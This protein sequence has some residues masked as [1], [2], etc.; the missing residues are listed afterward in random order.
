MSNYLTEFKDSMITKM[1]TPAA[2]S[3]AS[4]AQ[5]VNIRQST[6]SRWLRERG[7]VALKGEGMTHNKTHTWRA[8]EKLGALLEYERLSD[9]ERGKFLRGKGLMS[10]VTIFPCVR[11]KTA[12]CG[13]CL[14]QSATQD[15]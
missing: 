7:T 1:T 8:E 5:G 9:E 2:R 13:G 3:V 15:D 14:S 12:T 6:L 4:L 11:A 10:R